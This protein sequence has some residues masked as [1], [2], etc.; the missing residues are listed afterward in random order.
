MATLLKLASAHTRGAENAH[1]KDILKTYLTSYIWPTAAYAQEELASDLIFLFGDRLGDSEIEASPDF[2]EDEMD[3]PAM[4]T[5]RDEN[6]PPVSVQND[7]L[8]TQAIQ[9][10]DILPSNI[11]QGEDRKH[12]QVADFLLNGMQ[13]LLL[14]NAKLKEELNAAQALKTTRLMETSQIAQP[15]SD[16]VSSKM[17]GTDEGQS[18]AEAS[19]KLEAPFFDEF[20][21]VS[22]NNGGRTYFRDVPKMHKGDRR[23]DQLRGHMGIDHLEEFEARPSMAFALI[24][25]YECFCRSGSTSN[26]IVGY[27]DG[28]LAKDSPLAKSIGEHVQF[29]KRLQNAVKD[30]IISHPSSFDG[31]ASGID[32]HCLRNP[33]LPF[34]IHNK[35]FL[36]LADNSGL[37]PVSLDS[38]K[39]VC[40]W[41]EEHCQKDWDEADR[42]F[43]RGKVTAKHLDKLFRPG[44]LVLDQKKDQRGLIWVLKIENY[45]WT[46]EDHDVN[47]IVA[48]RWEFNGTFQKKKLALIAN[49][50]SMSD[51]DAFWR[52]GDIDITSLTKY[53]LR[54]AD[55]GVR[56]KLIARGH[57]FWS[58]RTKRLVAYSEEAELDT[59]P[60]Q[61]EDRLMVDYSI[62][63]R[64]HP[65]KDIFRTE[66]DDLGTD[67]VDKTEPPDGEFLAMMPPEIHA[68]DF[69]T[70]TWKL[71]RTD[72]ITDVTWNKDAFKR[73][74]I[75]AKNKELIEAAVTIHGS[76]LNMAPDIIAGKGQGL[77]ILLHGGPG[78]GKTL[79]A[80]S[81]AEAQERPLYRVTCG[82]I[83]IEPAEAE[84]KYLQSVLVIGKAWDCVVLL[85]EADVFLEERTGADQKQN[86]FVSVF[87]RVLE[88]Y[89]GILILT[90]N[91]VGTFDEAFKSRI[92]LALQYPKLDEEQ[93]AEIWRNFIHMLRRTKELIDVDDMERNIHKL[94]QIEMNGREIRNSLT[95]ARYLAK[96]RKE[97]LVYRHVQ[98]A[99]ASA[100]KF[101]DYLVTL[102]GSD[103]SWATES[104][105]R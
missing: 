9:T 84:K 31:F 95:M 14:E 75:P 102:R 22:C 98:D 53:P 32:Y 17:E 45:P 105:L 63:R 55:L 51:D 57:K 60:K 18:E 36:E 38:I 89:D 35:K 68:F 7:N 6:P 39:L 67:A 24:K 15:E 40:K 72:R 92:H 44:E 85:D 91:R 97:C 20:H 26:H 48:T 69:A 10:Q 4:L 62:F 71:I 33:Y 79:T 8:K 83:G 80:E 11:C 66:A 90:T 58:C 87:L 59:N 47:E 27:K 23:S 64:L 13:R 101:N 82:D 1:I 46:S 42:L 70:K 94:A 41:F 50:S 56:E 30:V 100:K 28:K 34:Y 96:F 52:G 81:I 19:D 74:V 21:V 29:G 3:T 54:F 77:L 103:D 49:A 76:H 16:N 12:T 5:V 78:T 86:A 93:R 104:R 25:E 99:V 37:E 65:Q 2:D 61:A 73:L 88:Y 43:S